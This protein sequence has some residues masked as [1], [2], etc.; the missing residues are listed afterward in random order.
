MLN[1]VNW[2][3]GSQVIIVNLLIIGL[4]SIPALLQ[5]NAD[6]DQTI[7]NNQLQIEKTSLI[8]EEAIKADIDRIDLVL[9]EVSDR[10]KN[11]SELD[12]YQV[13]HSKHTLEQIR[14]VN[15][16]DIK[17][18]NQKGEVMWSTDPRLEKLINI[19]DREF[20]LHLQQTNS[21][22]LY[23]SA[24]MIGKITKDWLFIVGKR[25]STKQGQFLGI[26]WCAIRP[27]FFESLKKVFSLAENDVFVIGVGSPAKYFYRFPN[28]PDLMGNPILEV[29]ETQEV[30]AHKKHAATLQ[31]VSPVDGKHRISGY[32]W[33]GSYPI[34]A[35]VGR[36]LDSALGIWYHQLRVTLGLISIGLMLLF[37]YSFSIWK[38]HNRKQEYQAKLA[39][40][41]KS[42]T[43]GEMSASLAHAINNPLA[44]IS[45]ISQKL[46]RMASEEKFSP[47]DLK[48]WLQKLQSPIDRIVSILGELKAVSYSDSTQAKLSAVQEIINSS[49]NLMGEKFINSNIHII[50][51]I[52]QEPVSYT[53]LTLPTIYSV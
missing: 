7:S 53:H 38:S 32:S 12:N 42:V 18:A 2:F 28:R 4:L 11:Q 46:Q 34:M 51:D 22:L 44:I 16:V 49:L 26:V 15:S 14:K 45:G 3:R 27:E 31:I 39:H 40:T 17:I 35:I 50:Q 30:L 19:A 36:N 52:P 37:S 6:Y 21:D 41:V 48:S 5:L 20:F 24:P 43:L 13:L 10:V 29:R 47:E 8:V 23:F 9:N 25:L 1:S 33:I